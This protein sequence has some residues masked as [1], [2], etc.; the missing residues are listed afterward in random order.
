MQLLPPICPMTTKMATD[1][2]GKRWRTQ[3]MRMTT[4]MDRAYCVTA[5]LYLHIRMNI[6]SVTDNEYQNEY[7]NVTDN[8]L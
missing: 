1:M 5:Y 6:T 3:M 4:W 8:E 2:S 7:N